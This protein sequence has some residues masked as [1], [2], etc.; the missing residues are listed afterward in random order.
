M[1]GQ[2]WSDYRAALLQTRCRLQSEVDSLL[3]IFM[4]IC[5]FPYSECP[6]QKRCCDAQKHVKTQLVPFCVNYSF[7]GA[8]SFR[9]YS[10]TLTK[11]RK[12]KD[13][14]QKPDA[15]WLNA[16]ARGQQRASLQTQLSSSFPQSIRLYVFT[17]G[18]PDRVGFDPDGLKLNKKYEHT[19][20]IK[21]K[22]REKKKI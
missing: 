4:S 5:G 10:L 20:K 13:R 11:Q 8:C 16:I 1:P 21:Y 6:E 7:D 22:I 15:M 17:H 19:Y 9:V 3:Q 2:L 18:S 14:A 12:T